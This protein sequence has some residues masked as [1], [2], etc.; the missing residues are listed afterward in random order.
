LIIMD[1]PFQHGEQYRIL[2][3][4]ILKGVEAE[5]RAFRE[6]ARL[7]GFQR[8]IVDDLYQ[9]SLPE[10][11]FTVASILLV[12]IPHPM[13]SDVT[14]A[15]GGRTYRCVSLV[16]SDFH[17]TWETVE[18]ELARR[19]RHAREAKR[20]PLKRLAVQGGLARYGR[21]NITY[22]DGLG[23]NFSY[24]A[25][26]TD[27]P[28][29]VCD[30]QPVQTAERCERCRACLNACPLGAIQADSFL[31]DN[32]RCLS[33]F[34][35]SGDPFPGWVPPAVH[36]SLYD[37][38]RCQ[39]VCPMNRDHKDDKGKDIHFTEEEVRFLLAGTPFEEY[40]AGLKEKGGYLG[41]DQWP[42]GIAINIRTLIE[43]EDDGPSRAAAAA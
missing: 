36:H 21:N 6:S 35:E 10:T 28:P 17:G 3:P 42:D 7:N 18:K 19:G 15:H 38:I 32:E 26:F 13:F 31:I 8:W 41:L 30:L 37:C 22:I 39:I 2:H 9:F 43:R 40:P 24:R 20:L 29:E 12:A 23:S 1:I 27:L 33:Y 5:L 11:T 14:F 16:S 34:N 4:S 25:F